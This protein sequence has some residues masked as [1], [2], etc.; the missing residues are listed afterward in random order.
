MG[1]GVDD[2]RCGS[3][4]HGRR[5]YTAEGRNP[6]AALGRLLARPRALASQPADQDLGRVACREA[7][8]T[9]SSRATPKDIFF[10]PTQGVGVDGTYPEYAIAQ[11]AYWLHNARLAYRLPQ[12][13]I[14]IAGWVRNFTDEVYE[15]FAFDASTAFSGILSLVGEPRTFGGSISISW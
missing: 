11:P 14:E 2:R 15:T 6:L 12:G 5:F 3:V 10:D 4:G 7:D 9:G 8:A 1:V 13:N